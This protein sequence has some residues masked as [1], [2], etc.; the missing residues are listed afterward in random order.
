MTLFGTRKNKN[1]HSKLSRNPVKEIFVVT[2]RV[3]IMH[4]VATISTDLVS[5]LPANPRPKNYWKS[6]EVDQSNWILPLEWNK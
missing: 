3:T 2:R 1:V 4:H 5:R 6:D